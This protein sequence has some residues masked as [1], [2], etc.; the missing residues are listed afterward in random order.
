MLGNYEVSYGTA[1]F[2]IGRKSASVSP[3]AASKTYGDDD[4]GFGGELSGFLAADGVTAAYS[5]EPGEAVAGSPYAISAVL[6]PAPVLANY[7]I[8]YET[9]E[10]T[11][12]KRSG[13]GVPGAASKTYGDDD[14]A[15]TG[16]LEGFLAADDVTASYSRAAGE[17]VA[18]GPYAISAS[19]APAEVLGNYDITYETAEFT[20]G[21]KPA[22]V[23]PAAAS[24]T[25]GDEDP[26]LSGTLDGFLAADSV[27]AGYSREP[28]ES[29]AGGPYVISASLAPA[30]VL[31]NYEIS[32][33]TAEFTIGRSR[34]RCRLR[35][36]A[37]PTA[38]RT[39]S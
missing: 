15:L 23:S 2:T 13:V 30:E 4:P 29:V 3:A 6:S 7:E 31:G 5:R 9:A 8:S 25:Y 12:E 28:G 27:T 1:E 39:R 26:V 32:Y 10:F 36:R 35:L 11:I 20:I 21:R 24:K 19:L 34:R 38:T 22:S 14:P 17:S 18:G 37:R 16:T 33:E